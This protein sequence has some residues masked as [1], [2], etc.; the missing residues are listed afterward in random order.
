[1]EVRRDGAISPEDRMNIDRILAEQPVEDMDRGQVGLQNVSHRL[2]LIYGE[3]SGFSI[4]EPVP[5]TVVA[6][7]T[8][9]YLPDVEKD[10][11]HGQ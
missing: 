9:P 6:R 4:T 5:G 11:K 7:V 3:N 10:S 1:M 2:R 8:I